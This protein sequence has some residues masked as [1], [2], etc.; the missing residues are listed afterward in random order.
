MREKIFDIYRQILGFYSNT[1]GIYLRLDINVLRHSDMF[2][3]RINPIGSNLNKLSL[4]H[5]VK[6]RDGLYIFLK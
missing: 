3:S 5:R 1:N 2:L 6:P 4:A